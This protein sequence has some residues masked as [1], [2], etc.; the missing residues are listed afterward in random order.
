MLHAGFD[1]LGGGALQLGVE[2]GVDAQRGVRGVGVAEALHDLVVDQVDEVG[3]F[4]GVDVG[5]S[6]VERLGLGALGFAGGDGFGLDHGVEDEVAALHGAVGMA[7][8]IEVAGPLDDAGE[9]GALGEVELAEVFAE[10][11]LRGL[12]EAV[13]AVRAALA[14]G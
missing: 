10:V 13:D 11:G 8:G 6:E 2:R 1:G 14:R 7:V 12:A 5:R 9:Q 3:R 4:A